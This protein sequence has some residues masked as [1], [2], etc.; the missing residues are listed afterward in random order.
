M[1]VENPTK[2]HLVIFPKL[3]CSGMFTVCADRQEA[4]SVNINSCADLRQDVLQLA[5][6]V[7]KL[8]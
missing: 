4:Q 1:T 8:H 5:C 2:E 3:Y 7:C 6:D